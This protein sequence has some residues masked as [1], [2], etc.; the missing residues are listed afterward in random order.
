MKRLVTFLLAA[1][2]ILSL[3][4]CSGGDTGKYVDGTYTSAAEGRAG[5]VNVDVT[6][7]KGKISAINVLDNHETEAMLESVKG[8]LIP[9]IIELQTT[10]GVDTV[11]G[12]TLTSKAVLEAVNNI[13]TQD[14]AKDAAK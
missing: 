10:E 11:S 9:K 12:A 1:T 8:A 3:T 4:G 2:L 13:L 14:A 7:E 6:I 5:K